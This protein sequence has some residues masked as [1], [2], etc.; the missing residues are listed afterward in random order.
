MKDD[1]WM[2]VMLK[3]KFNTE[4]EKQQMYER[5]KNMYGKKPGE[6]Y[7]FPKGTQQ[8][9][10]FYVFIKEDNPRQ[11]REKIR[12]EKYFLETFDYLTTT[13]KQVKAMI[14]G[15]EYKRDIIFFGDVV[16]I[17][18]GKF[19]KLYGIVLRLTRYNQIV[20][21][22]KMCCGVFCEEYKESDLQVVG[23]IF[24]YIKVNG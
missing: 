12:N 4:N 11:F 18:T 20:V 15:I 9:L 19:R 1:K 24:K 23:N 3:E 8:G 16:R 21:G 17:K 6:V 22:M 14:H 7:A 10:S 13:E 5:L 2:I